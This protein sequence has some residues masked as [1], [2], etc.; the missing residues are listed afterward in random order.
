MIFSI[1]LWGKESKTK[2]SVKYCAIIYHSSIYIYIFFFNGR[3][4]G[5]KKYYLRKKEGGGT[6]SRYRFL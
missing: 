5:K 2:E 1:L 6:G 3:I 4:N